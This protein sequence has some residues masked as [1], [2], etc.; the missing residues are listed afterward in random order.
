M[1]CKLGSA[2][3]VP[4]MVANFRY[5]Y[6]WRHC[7]QETSHQDCCRVILTALR[8]QKCGMSEDCSLQSASGATVDVVA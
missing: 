7:A 1:L 8:R 3:F 5:R 6:D 4:E 2:D